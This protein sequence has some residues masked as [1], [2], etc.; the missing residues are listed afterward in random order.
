VQILASHDVPTTYREPCKHPAQIMLSFRAAAWPGILRLPSQLCAFQGRTIRLG[1][2][3]APWLR[4]GI[5]RSRT[6]VQEMVIPNPLA[7]SFEGSAYFAV[8]GE[9]SAFSPWF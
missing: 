4:P 8:G 1:F 6:I 3:G 2:H 7:L 5:F 9:G